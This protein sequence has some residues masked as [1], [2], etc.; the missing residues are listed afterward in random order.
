MIRFFRKIRQRLLTENKFGKYTLYA[1]GEV[2]ILIAG[3]L[4]A[5]HVGNMN[6]KGQNKANE[7]AILKSMKT[8]LQ[9]DLRDIEGNIK[10]HEIGIAA[11]Q[12]ILNHLEKDLPYNDSLGVHFLDT[13]IV[14]VFISQNGAYKTLQSLGVG[15]ISNEKLRN[16]IIDVYAWYEVII[17]MEKL[18]ADRMTHAENYIFNSRFDGLYNIDFGLTSDPQLV[19]GKMIPMDYEA[20]KDDDEYKFFLRTYKGAN[21]QYL[22]FFAKVVKNKVSELIVSI[23]K[24][25]TMLEQ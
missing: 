19:Q 4:I 17:R 21:I 10:I 9:S 20:L 16:Q 6:E 14:T 24:E 23:E 13:S 8:E 5:L 11:A 2:L 25:L 1:I 18:N 15:L 12:I 3:I 22:E 7:I